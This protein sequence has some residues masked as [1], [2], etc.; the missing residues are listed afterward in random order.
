MYGY[1]P[2]NGKFLIDLIPVY[3]GKFKDE[4]AICLRLE[5][6]IDTYH[7][8]RN[9]LAHGTEWFDAETDGYSGLLAGRYFQMTIVA[10]MYSYQIIINGYHFTTYQHRIPFYKDMRVVADDHVRMEPM[11]YY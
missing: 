2:K 4:V 5:V 1:A 11:E 6:D 9:S 8:S 3:E 7:I 10:Q